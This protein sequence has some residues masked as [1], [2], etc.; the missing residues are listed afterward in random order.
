MGQPLL[1]SVIIAG[2]CSAD[3][4]GNIVSEQAEVAMA[5]G[6]KKK[7]GA[8]TKGRKKDPAMSQEVKLIICDVIM[9]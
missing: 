1:I 3:E 7:V 4:D 5:A 6:G 8:K 2:L 9:M